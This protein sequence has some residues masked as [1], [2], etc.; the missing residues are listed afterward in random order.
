MTNAM[1]SAKGYTHVIM[2]LNMRRFVHP[3]DRERFET[4]RGTPQFAE[5]FTLYLEREISPP[6]HI[7]SNTRTC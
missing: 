6:E 3:D 2:V 4:V 5:F 7:R 1:M